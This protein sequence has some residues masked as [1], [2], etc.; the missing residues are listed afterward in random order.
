M[1]VTLRIVIVNWNVCDLLQ[2]CLDSVFASDSGALLPDGSLQLGDA[3]VRV[4]VVDN[5]STDDSVAMLRRWYPQ[6]ELV[7]SAVNRGFAGGQNLALAD[8]DEDY[9][10]L[11][12]PDTKLAPTALAE[13]LGY[14][15]AH[16][17]VGVVGPRLVYGDGSPQSSRRRFPTLMMALMESTLLE[18]WFPHNRWRRAYH[19]GD[20]P[21]DHDQLV[22]WVNGSCL[23]ARGRIL[24]EVG[25]LDEGY[26]MYSE[27]LDWCKRIAAAGW[28]IAF[29]PRAVVTHFEGR[30]SSQV[31]AA[32]QMRFETSKIRYFRKHH[33]ALTAE[34]L[35]LFLLATF[36]LRLASEAAKWCLGHKRSL[37]AERI[38]AYWQLLRS[39]LRP[40]AGARA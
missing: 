9:V 18:Q 17:T 32:R 36:C 38:A 34:F 1:G 33:G 12:N 14:L 26:F 23:L 29:V 25:L 21:D 5:A 22:D 35:R 2:Q 13:L 30:S 16:P 6:V 40:A 15:E 39:G 31:V 3:A 28:Q 11:L 24:R 7:V 37:R 4:T 8:C 20:V 27:E 19:L 10:M